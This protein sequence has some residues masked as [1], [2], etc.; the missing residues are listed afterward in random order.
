MGTLSSNA[1]RLAKLEAA[2]DVQSR[3]PIRV[4]HP[5]IE[6]GNDA[7]IGVHAG[8]R[9]FGRLQE[10]SVE[11]NRQRAFVSVGWMGR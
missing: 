9:Y 5:I 2:T 11:E 1:T 8:G 6:P 7:P 10:E 4:W 3:E